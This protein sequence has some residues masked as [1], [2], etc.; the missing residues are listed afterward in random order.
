MSLYE[1][2]K[3]WNKGEYYDN[4]AKL[5]YLHEHLFKT[6]PTEEQLDILTKIDT[7]REGY[8]SLLLLLVFGLGMMLGA[9]IQYYNTLVIGI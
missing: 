7:L 6:K 8:I 2:Y 5:R 1:K 9:I 4:F 3:K